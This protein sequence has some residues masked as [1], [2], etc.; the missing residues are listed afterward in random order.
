MDACARMVPIKNRID[1]ERGGTAYLP[2]YIGRISAINQHHRTAHGGGERAANL[3]H[4]DAIR[5]ALPVKRN[6]A[7]YAERR[8]GAV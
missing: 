1:A 3:E 8:A 7:R 6:R 4:K 2:E 5:V